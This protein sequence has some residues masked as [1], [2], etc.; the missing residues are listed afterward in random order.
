GLALP[1]PRPL[2]VRP[3]RGGDRSRAGSARGDG[4]RAP[5]IARRAARARGSMRALGQVTGR[6][7]IHCNAETFWKIFFDKDFNEQLYRTALGFPKFDIVDQKETDSTLTR[8]AA[9]TPKMEMPAPVVK[10]L[11]SNFGYIEEGTFEKGKQLWT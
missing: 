11:G 2:L 6:H 9:G 8:K 5:L 3:G 7:E 1:A 4:G 10:V